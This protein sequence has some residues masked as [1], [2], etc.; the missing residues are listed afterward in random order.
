MNLVVLSLIL[1]L[2]SVRAQDPAQFVN[3]FIGTQNGGHVFPGATLP[4][5]SVK[6]G[7]DSR[8]G[9]NQA[10][11]VS[12]GSPI[13][14]ISQLHDDG[15]GG[16]ASL[17]QFAL[18]PL[19]STECAGNDLTKCTLDRS[20]RALGHGEPSASPGYFG[21]PLNNGVQAEVTVT[22]HTAL[23]R[24]TYPAGTEQM[25]LLLDV[26]NDLAERYQGDG[27]VSV[28]PTP[29]P[30]TS[31]S[32]RAGTR[33]TGTG[34]WIPSFG[35]KTYQVYFC[36]DAPGA[37]E[38]VGAQYY[39]KEG[40]D[41]V[42]T[43][44]M[45]SEE[46]EAAE[47]AEGEKGRRGMA[48]FEKDIGRD[49]PA[50]VVLAFSP[51]SSSST[52][53]QPEAQ[54]RTR[55]QSD[56]R[57]TLEIRMGGVVDEHGES[58][59]D[60]R[61]EW[62]TLLS[63]IELDTTGV[64]RDTLELFWSS[65]YRTYIAPVNVTGDNPLW[66]STEPYWDSFYCIWD[67]FRV[68]HPLYA[69]TAP[70]AQAEIIR[71]LIDVYRHAGWLPDCRMS[72]DKGFT[73]GGS[74]ADSLLGDSVGGGGLTGGLVGIA[75]RIAL[76]T[77]A[78]GVDWQT[79]LEAMVK[80]ATVMGDFEVEGRGGVNSREKLGYVPVG[81]TDHPSSPGSNTRSASRLLEYA[82]NDFDIA[83]VALGMGNT[84]LAA[85]YFN[86]SHD[87]MNIWNPDAS[88]SGF[89]GFIQPRN[90][91]G[92][93]FFSQYDYGGVFRPDHCSPVYGHTDCYGGWGGGE[94]YEASSWE[95]SFYVPHDMARLVGL[96]GGKETFRYR[97]RLDHFFE[98]GFHDMGDEPGFLPT[99]LYNYIGQPT[100]TVDRVDQ[101]VAMYYNTS[102]NGLPGNDDSGSMGAYAVWSHLGFFPVAG[103]S[104]YLLNRPYF[105]KITIRNPTSGAVAIII[106]K[107][108][109]PEN[110]YIQSAKLNGD[111][112]TKNWISHDLF[113]YGGTLEL[114]MGA[115][116]EST[117]GTKAGD[118]PMSLS[119]GGFGCKEGCVP[120][121][122]STSNGTESDSTSS[123][124]ED[125]EEAAVI[126]GNSGAAD[127]GGSVSDEPLGTNS[128]WSYLLFLFL[129][130]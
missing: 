72:G 100:K 24:F 49:A 67:T 71:A 25:L 46:E 64:P 90:A 27:R 86:K 111:K 22:Q 42:F 129:A 73:Q 99:Y 19:T 117:W 34:R 91:D 103:Q 58:V 115:S 63:S 116:K 93:W 87:W 38:V 127:G 23:H 61:A 108:F 109:S 80:D 70:T 11:F 5:G 40:R 106:A 97:A 56:M 125:K 29:D 10:G 8:S 17:G 75:G 110:K 15:T 85:H 48:E 66:E 79:G 57:P 81:D 50:G 123:E 18:L 68:V 13:T 121:G 39:H 105:P 20:A 126:P 95:Y 1:T 21:I 9:D 84:T 98:A 94:F 59:A 28:S 124:P 30:T 4:W 7:A 43:D 53:L 3:P 33:I 62:N 60:A 120:A 16:S 76:E 2:V 47:R 36:F 35:Q 96:M 69:I 107:N 92:S 55:Q 104:T 31:S 51:R 54:E 83:L 119:T 41:Y 32:L 52:G 113:M 114:V 14:G 12:D 65:L 45:T 74:N 89:T 128:F 78:M 82:Y 102:V 122:A 112:Y 6:P 37:S 88:H 44:L 101:M 118:L 26:T 130:D 77:R